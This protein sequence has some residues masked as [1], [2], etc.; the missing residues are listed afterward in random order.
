MRLK[1]QLT[2]RQ[3]AVKKKFTYTISAL[4]TTRHLARG[5]VPADLGVAYGLRVG[6]IYKRHRDSSVY[7]G[8]AH[9]VM[10]MS[11]C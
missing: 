7:T 5:I 10:K 9:Y 1:V 8:D 4:I 6:N 2:Q 11:T 3:P